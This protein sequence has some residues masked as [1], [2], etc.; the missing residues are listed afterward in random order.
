MSLNR[1][2]HA[3]GQVVFD[4]ATSESSSRTDADSTLQSSI[5]SETSARVS[6]DSTLQSGL[7]SEISSRVLSDS[8]LTSSLNAEVS[9]RS[10][11]DSSL[12]SSINSEITARSSATST[13]Q[14][15]IDFE[16]TARTNAD[17]T[18]TTAVASVA[19][20]VNIG[21]VD[22]VMTPSSP[23][24]Q[25][26]IGQAV[27]RT[28][29]MPSSGM[30]PGSVYRFECQTTS[31][32]VGV[33][34]E[35]YCVYVKASG[36]GTIAR[37]NAGDS[38]NC[39]PL[40][41]SPTLPRHYSTQIY[42]KKLIGV[43]QIWTKY[44]APIGNWNSVIW[45]DQLGLFV[46]VGAKGTGGTAGSRVMTSPDGKNWTSQTTP[47]DY[48]WNCVC[49]SPEYGRLVAV[50]SSGTGNRVMTSTS[51]VSWSLVSTPVDNNW[52]SVCWS[53]ELSLFVAVA[54]GAG[55]GN[56]VMR[57]SDGLTWTI[58][59]GVPDM[60]WMS[61]CW[62]AE[63]GKFMAV[64]NA[65]SNRTMRSLDGITWTNMY[66]GDSNSW[67]NVIYASE[68]GLY[69][70]VDNVG[71]TQ[72]PAVTTDCIS[73]FSNTPTLLPGGSDLVA[74]AWSPELRMFAGVSASFYVVL[75]STDGFRWISRQQTA[76]V[77]DHKSICWSPE[78]GM[79]VAVGWAGGSSQNVLT[80]TR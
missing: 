39:V 7:S 61:V 53:N 43:S 47:A 26:F 58:G 74:V 19:P 55:T 13:L 59:S 24:T 35:N 15:S 10:A 67:T 73:N 25:I 9:S 6:S 18:L 54:S 23:K 63:P 48:S 45:V 40:I 56:R 64:G 16:S 37:L 52:M 11:T 70:C 36:G 42:R 30:T 33:Y 1:L 80:S 66:V 38:C 41:A 50:A 49:W 29:T 78:L 69:V 77:I 17:S 57:S 68:L 22:V 32:S 44:N 31:S 79:F 20:S 51:A 21:S 2:V 75:T 12:T 60:Q 46:A 71:S 65:G 4:G 72:S 62:G 5:S 34:R 28:V 3:S 76:G 8:T 27:A 14:A